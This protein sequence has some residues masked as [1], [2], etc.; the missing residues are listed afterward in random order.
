MND[1]S[2]ASSTQ[3]ASVLS[4]E[5]ELET[6]LAE[7][8]R[9]TGT[10]IEGRIDLAFIFVSPHWREELAAIGQA[11]GKQFDI[12]CLL[13]CTGE[14]IVGR[15]Q[16]VEGEPAISVLLARLPGATLLPMHLQ[17]ERSPE[18]GAIV[19]WHDALQSDWPQHCTFLMLGEPFSFPA[20]ILLE[21]FNE[22]RAGTIVVG[23]M[24][25]GGTSPGDNHLLLDAQN[26]REG[27]VAVMIH[28]GANIRTVVS[29]GCRPIGSHFV[30]TKA[31][32]N[33]IH[34]LGGQPA[35]LQLKQIFDTLP[36]SE[37]AQVQQG[38]HVGRVVSE[39]QDSFQQGDFLV[40]NVIGID[41][42]QGTIAIGDFVR[43]GQTV[44]FHIRDSHSADAELKQLLAVVRD[45]TQ[46][47]PAAA[48]LFTCNGRGT[49]LFDTPHH[50]AA[51]LQATLGD[52]PLAGFFAQG[53]LGP[54][55][56][57]NFMHGFTAS[58]ALFDNT[59]S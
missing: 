5:T 3:F 8:C 54:I 36:T 24:A 57:N 49:R 58:I 32:Q 55:G 31:E 28:G 42:D 6:A 1:V 19:G 46:A 17:F 16:E 7:I 33:V 15:G 51:T 26:H 52:I 34:E 41:P 29:Q 9:Q 13:G 40:R 38:L 27:A 47:N 44:Q 50:D 10:Q 37:Q 4:T 59:S 43:P 20:D 11:I 48:L 35:L 23:G 30:I 22:D 39:Y 18:G 21:R 25:S 53:E 14:S 12:Q 2:P 45:D 56:G